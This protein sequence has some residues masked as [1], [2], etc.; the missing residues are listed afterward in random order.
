MALT[1]LLPRTSRAPALYADFWFN[2]EPV[3][4]SAL[5]GSVLFLFFWE[6]SCPQSL[7]FLPYVKEWSRKYSDAGLVTVGIH[8][9]RFGFAK[10]PE[11]IQKAMTR[12]GISF[13]FAMDNEGFIA[14]SYGIRSL[15]AGVIIDKYGYIR[16]LVSTDGAFMAAERLLQGY[17]YDIGLID[18]LPTL[19]DPIREIDRE[20]A[21]AYHATPELKA[22]YLY[23][24]LGNVEGYSP[25]SYVDYVD[26]GIYLDGRFYAEGTW[27]NGRDCL[28][29]AAEGTKEGHII[30][31]YQGTDV[32]GVL[33][34]SRG[35]EVRMSVR[36]DREYL[37]RETGGGDVVI[38][39]DGSSVL[40]VS[41]P[42][43][44]SIAKNKEFGEHIIRLSA[45]GGDLSV[46]AISFGS[47]LIPDLIFTN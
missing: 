26:P 27:L 15:P 6:Y 40:P 32:S 4:V 44:Y 38:G 35:S 25:E 1:E 2:G 45:S 41:E 3:I 23:G 24:S 43:L 10:D 12:L 28:Q 17:V 21:V 14:A 5:Q 13:P 33:G 37:T 18:E 8:T 29:L 11:G 34:S 30:I 20:G 36:Q 39:V 47:S 42:R 9:P 46:Y 7:R 31:S 19:M 16:A 22:G